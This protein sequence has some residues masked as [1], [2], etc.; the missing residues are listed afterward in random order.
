MAA[1][2]DQS[3]RSLTADGARGPIIVT[4]LAIA[5]LAAWASWFFFAEMTVREAASARIEVHDGVFR[6]VAELLP[7][8]SLGRIW[9]GQKGQLR[10]TAF[11]WTQYGTV[12]VEVAKV[13]DEARDGLV[14][15]ELAIRPD[16]DARIPLTRD[17]PGTID[18][19]V[20][21][22]SPAALVLRVVGRFPGPPVRPQ[23]PERQAQQ[24]ARP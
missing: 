8:D 18:I 3:M 11:P 19:E 13:A 2:F 10:L 20:E 17:L 9:P 23:H 21:H 7:E 1:P 16:Y 15:V 5:L 12:P 22:L 24:E 4:W 6:V 14:R